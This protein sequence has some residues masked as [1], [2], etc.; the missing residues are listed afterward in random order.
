[1]DLGGGIT[2]ENIISLTLVGEDEPLVT[3]GMYNGQS[4]VRPVAELFDY[5]AIAEYVNKNLTS[6]PVVKEAAQVTVLNGSGTSGAAV[7]E[8]EKLEAL[9]FVINVTDN[10]PDGSYG[11]AEIY[12]INKDKTASAAKL[13]E[14]YGVEIKTTAPPVSVVGETDFLIIIG[15]ASE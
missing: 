13:K 4:I 12:Q 9:G 15:V 8:A 7:A 3:T 5:R 10:A 6:D 1:M 2:S 14:L 11:K